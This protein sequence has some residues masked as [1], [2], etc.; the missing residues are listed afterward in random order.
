MDFSGMEIPHLKELR[1]PI[2]NN[3]NMHSLAL[4]FNENCVLQRLTLD[5]D[6]ML[7][8]QEF[9]S[10]QLTKLRCLEFLRLNL[11]CFTPN[12]LQDHFTNAIPSTVKD[13]TMIWGNHFEV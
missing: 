12:T 5:I 7:P 10:E 1:Y 4:A 8:L 9:L 3:G 11:L 13:I 6:L 2:R